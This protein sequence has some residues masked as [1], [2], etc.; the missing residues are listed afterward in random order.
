MYGRNN[1]CRVACFWFLVLV[2]LVLSTSCRTTQGVGIVKAERIKDRTALVM[3]I[4][5]DP[6][7]TEKEKVKAIGKVVK[8]IDRQAEDLGKDRDTEAVKAESN[9]SAAS[10]WRWL[11]GSVIALI[12]IVG[13]WFGRG[14]ILRI[15]SG[16][17]A[18]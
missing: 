5:N 6:N 15:F 14:F 10:K 16:G 12:V 4:L 2:V 13:L 9:A 1:Y 7:F 3:Q 8:E 11:V 18:K 17:I